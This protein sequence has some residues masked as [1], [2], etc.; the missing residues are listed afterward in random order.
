MVLLRRRRLTSRETGVLAAIGVDRVPVY[1][2]PRVAVL[3]T[4]DEIVAPGAPLQV[5]RVYDS[6]QRILLDAVAELGGEPRPGGRAVW[7]GPL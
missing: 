4:G 1:R 5:G 7:T 6:N 2:R 3:S